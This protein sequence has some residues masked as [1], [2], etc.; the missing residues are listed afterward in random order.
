MFA[1]VAWSLLGLALVAIFFLGSGYRKDAALRREFRVLQSDIRSRLKNLPLQTVTE[2]LSEF[3]ELERQAVQRG[4]SPKI[5]RRKSLELGISC[6]R[7]ALRLDDILPGAQPGHEQPDMQYAAKGFAGIA[8]LRKTK[9]TANLHTMAKANAWHYLQVGASNHQVASAHWGGTYAITDDLVLYNRGIEAFGEAK[10]ARG[11]GPQKGQFDKL[12]AAA[13]MY[14]TQ[15]LAEYP[16]EFERFL[17]A[18]RGA[19]PL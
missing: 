6:M 8:T 3:M 12:Y 5:A 17:V 16:E 9:S 11:R 19:P 14:L 1:V 4:M 13:D 2:T 15:V 7:S 10:A 18:Q